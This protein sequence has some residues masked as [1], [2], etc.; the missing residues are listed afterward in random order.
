MYWANAYQHDAPTAMRMFLE[1][2]VSPEAHQV[3]GGG[4]PNTPNKADQRA[5]KPAAPRPPSL[6]DIGT[7][8]GIVRSY[9][10]EG[11]IDVTEL[12][13]ARQAFMR[14]ED[15]IDN[16]VSPEAHPHAGSKEKS[17]GNYFILIPEGRPCEKCRQPE[18]V[19]LN[20]SRGGYGVTSGHE[21]TADC[22]T[23]RCDHGM[24]H[25]DDCDDCEAIALAAGTDDTCGPCCSGVHERCE[26]SGCI[27]DHDSEAK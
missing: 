4:L 10:A 6:I 23:L 27:C 14:I 24:L 17:G 16:Q 9:L 7:S 18:G 15:A 1:E 22:P 20:V 21:H 25:S 12:R 13:K 26:G 3:E 19:K 11:I 2:L 8:R 5:V